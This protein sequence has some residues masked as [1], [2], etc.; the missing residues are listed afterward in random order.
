MN[1]MVSGL[2]DIAEVSLAGV[3]VKF[4]AGFSSVT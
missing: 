4:L 2:K 1:V 3:T